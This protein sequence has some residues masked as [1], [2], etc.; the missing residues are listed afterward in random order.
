MVDLFRGFLFSVIG[1]YLNATCASAMVRVDIYARNDDAGLKYLKR[2]CIIF[3]LSSI[4]E[5]ALEPYC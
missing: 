3:F 4:I 1:C 2:L 5:N